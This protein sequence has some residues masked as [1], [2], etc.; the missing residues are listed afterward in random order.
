MV[1]RHI[2]KEI[3][4]LSEDLATISQKDGATGP[5]SHSIEE[6]EVTSCRFAMAGLQPKARKSVQQGVKK[7]N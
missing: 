6:L 1:L 4:G 2:K 5:P 7:V 3:L